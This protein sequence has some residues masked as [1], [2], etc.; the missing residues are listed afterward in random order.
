M[1]EKSKKWEIEAVTETSGVQKHPKAVLTRYWH[2]QQAPASLSKDQLQQQFK[3]YI[4]I[5]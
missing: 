5:V 4:K 1:R 2:N 3:H